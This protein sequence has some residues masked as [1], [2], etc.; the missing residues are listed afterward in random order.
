MTEI[1]ST[2]VTVPMSLRSPTRLL[3]DASVYLL[4]ALVLIIGIASSPQFRTVDNLVNVLRSI[5]LIGI[6][7]LGMNFVIIAGSLVDLSVAVVVS[8]AAVVTL[9]FSGVSPF[10]SVVA[11]VGIAIVVGWGNGLLLR[12]FRANPILL[13]LAT[14]TIVGGLLLFAT[15]GR[16]IY[17][18]GT[19]LS[20]TVN[21]R[22]FGIPVVVIVLV[23]LTVLSQLALSRTT[24]G[25]RVVAVG[26][27]EDAATMSGIAIGKVR[28]QAFTVC[29]LFAGVTGFLLGS[30]SGAAG[31]TLGGGYE[32]D[33][34]TAAVV[35]GTRLSGGKGSAYGVLAGALLVGMLSNLLILW[36]APFALQQVIKG[37]LLIVVVALGQLLG[38]ARND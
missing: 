5:S 11:S 21:G 1:T 34:L 28:M 29:A 13:T 14:S 35:G 15:S 8:V 6:A 32:F 38:S 12:K 17:E 4:I 37:V 30:S 24:W 7:A 10:L 2:S 9:G 31:A 3:L 33:A 18:T 23:V 22:V 19:A 26:G 16:V 25:R 27:N 20:S 36:G